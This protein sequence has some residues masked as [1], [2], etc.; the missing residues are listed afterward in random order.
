LEYDEEALQVVRETRLLINEY[1][2]WLVEGIRPFLGQRVIEVGCGLGNLLK[3][4]I[5]RELAIGIETSPETVM[6]AKRKFASVGNVSI[7]QYSITDASV[8]ALREMRFDSAI[9]LNV[10]E[11][12][13]DDELAM[14]HTALL[15]EPYGYFALI[16]PAHQWLYGTMD[17]SIGH[18]RRY[19]KALAKEK[20]EKTGFRIAHQKYLNILGAIGW[21][22]NARFLRRKVPPSAQLRMFNK[23][24]PILKAAE[25]VFPPPFGI[26]LI[27]VAQR[28]AELK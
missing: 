24:V 2:S 23:I 18:Y 7:Y 26:S 17:G 13:E 5:D 14:Q 21:F 22:V 4:F 27:T 10:F 28:K 20:L 11:H 3:H 15:L 16:V 8:L 1:D 6:E 12:I 19:T 25:R 9:S